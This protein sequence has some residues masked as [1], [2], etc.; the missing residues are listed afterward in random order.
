MIVVPGDVTQVPLAEYDALADDAAVALNALEAPGGVFLVSGNTDPSITS[1]EQVADAA[2]ITSLSD[3][4][5]EVTVDGQRLRLLG[6]S[7]PN[8]RRAA[9]VDALAEFAQG[10]S[11]LLYTS[12]S[13]RDATLSRMPS[14]A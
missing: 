7:W 1:I 10:S 13:P 2:G 11:C 14:S 12:P 4:V 8:N 6:L 9:V 5:A 3:E